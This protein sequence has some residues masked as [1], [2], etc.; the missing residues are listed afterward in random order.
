VPLESH[1][2]IEELPPSFAVIVDLVYADLAFLSTSEIQL[3]T[4]HHM[5]F[6]PPTFSFVF[7]HAFVS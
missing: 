7:L 3:V 1:W 4:I 5:D 6:P 2:P